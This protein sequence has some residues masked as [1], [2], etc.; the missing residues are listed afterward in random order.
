MISKAILQ[1]AAQQ[2]IIDAAQ[3]D[4]LY[5]FIHQQALSQK[6]DQGPDQNNEPLKFIRSFGDV[7]ITLGIILIVMAITMAELTGYYYL[8][9]L[10]G[11]IALAE[12]LV[13][14]RRLALPGIAILISILLF[15]NKLVPFGY[16][17]DV[18]IALA[19]LSGS[20]L[21]F[22]L[23]YKM[24]FSLFPLMA[25]LVAMPVAQTGLGVLTNPALFVGFGLI[26]F[27][28]AFWFD[29][30]DTKRIS[31]L[32][33]SAFWL[34]LLASPLIVHGVMISVFLSRH[35][36]VQSLNKE[37]LMIV[38]FTIF[39]LVSLL[40]DRRAMLIS[41][42]LYIIYALT[43]L[44]Q[45]GLDNSQHV[46]LYTLTG[47]GLFVIYFGSYWY[48]TRNLI[49]GFMKGSIIS[50]FIPDLALKDNQ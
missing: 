1:K 37:I 38:F 22:Y 16:G 11:F 18:I 50:K 13:R 9:P 4:A 8:L 34:Y 44:L 14:L 24:P 23:R 33:D 21:L 5:Q 43:Q 25:A 10:A 20:S 48:K 26:I 49:F 47:L 7:F 40:I 35:E 17:H 36:W 2:K 6:S 27:I 28:I 3:V 30:Q 32:S 12:W 29:A 15:V 42:Q 45:S 39:F 31:H 46:M 19:V 41:T